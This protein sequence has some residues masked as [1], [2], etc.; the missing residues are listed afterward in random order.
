MRD[1][2]APRQL[3]YSSSILKL[4]KLPLIYPTID[5]L[6]NIDLKNPIFERYMYSIYKV[7]T[8][9]NGRNNLVK[10][11]D[12]FKL[13]KNVDYFESVRREIMFHLVLAGNNLAIIQ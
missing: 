3:P 12:K 6:Y 5:H 11:Y 13:L 9:S 10:I 7:I 8:I 4:P 2:F 1:I